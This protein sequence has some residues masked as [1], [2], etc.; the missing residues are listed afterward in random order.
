LA[1]LDV[2]MAD[3][4]RTGLASVAD[5]NEFSGEQVGWLTRRDIC[6]DKE[7][8]IVAYNDRIKDLERWARR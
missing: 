5:T 7:C 8:L 3:L 1:G 2:K 4:Y 6:T